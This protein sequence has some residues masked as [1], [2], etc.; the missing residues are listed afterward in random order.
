MYGYQEDSIP[1]A[2]PAFGLNAGLARVTKFEWI[3]TA[4]VGGSEGEALDVQISVEGIDRPINLRLFPVKKAFL[5]NNG[6]ETTDPKHPEF[7]KAVKE[8]NA[9]IV[10]LMHCFVP[11]ETLRIALGQPIEN[12]KEFCKILSS[13]LPK[14]YQEIPLDI[15]MQY[16]WAIKGE[17][18][19]TF[20]ELPKNMKHGRWL[21]TAVTPVGSW[22]EVRTPN[23]SAALPVAL[24]YVDDGGNIHP[25]VRNGWYMLSNFAIQQKENASGAGVGAIPTGAAGETP[26]PAGAG[27]W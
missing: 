20:L 7:I 5:P 9:S 1:S 24:K 16:Q 2:Q 6:G 21:C 12:F 10:H 27:S 18:T 19:M 3:N 11:D 17:T 23:P 4:G 22:K 26:A 14:N 25:F 15:F 8:L 13:L